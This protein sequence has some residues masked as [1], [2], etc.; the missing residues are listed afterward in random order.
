MAKSTLG[1]IHCENTRKHLNTM[2]NQKKKFQNESKNQA[3]HGKNGW[4]LVS[5][6]CYL[7]ST[8]SKAI[9]TNV[10]KLKKLTF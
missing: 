10:E 2:K 4:T 9:Y 8:I 1:K 6:I 5:T 7:V 3:E